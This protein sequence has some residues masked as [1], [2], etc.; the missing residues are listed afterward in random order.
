MALRLAAPGVSAALP[1]L[2]RAS[3]TAGDSIQSQQRLQTPPHLCPHSLP[4]P[5]KTY[6]IYIDTHSLSL[7]LA[8]PNLGFA[9]WS[10]AMAEEAEPTLNLKPSK[11]KLKA[12]R[13]K[14]HEDSTNCCI[15][16]PQ[17]PH[18]IV[19]SGDVSSSLSLFS[20][21]RLIPPSYFLSLSLLL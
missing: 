4:V 3:S 11:V 20:N 9:S 14:G 5:P 6:P 2:I 13:L 19:T 17:Q 12:R 21:S 18:L 8:H 16:S 1:S 7:S 10:G 15:A